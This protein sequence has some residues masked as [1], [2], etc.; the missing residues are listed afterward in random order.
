MPIATPD[1]KVQGY[2]F[3]IQRYS[4]HDGEGI[5]TNV[6][7]K[8]CPLRCRWCSNPESQERLPELARNEGRCLG[9]EKCDYCANACPNGALGLP[10][11]GMPII[12]RDKCKRCMAC[13]TAC[14]AGA[15]M[16][17]GTLQSVGEVIDVVEKDS[18][19]YARSGGGMTMSGGE[20][21][22][23]AD[24]ALALLREAKRRRIHTAVETCGQVPWKVYEEAVPLLD[25][26][27]FD[28]KLVDPEKHKKHTGATNELILS[29]IKNIIKNFPKL[30]LCIRTPVIPGVNDTRQDIAD[31]VEFL[32]PYPGVRYELLAY[33]RL[34]TQKYHFLDR[35]YPMG[36][37]TLDNGRM[38]S[39]AKLVAARQTV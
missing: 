16:P 17:Y 1:S 34:G 2:V 30:N 28:I 10:E 14:P 23:Q 3:N 35:E 21:F 12:L 13:A 31:I 33:H 9:V 20:P 4:V 24:F 36:E 37:V 22:M 6:F 25:E 27:M 8:G 7:L 39:L 11:K 19:F 18:I 29:N 26:M 38:E 15:L 32:A 5:R